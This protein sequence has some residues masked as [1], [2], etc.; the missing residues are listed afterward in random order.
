MSLF[1]KKRKE[2]DG[3]SKKEQPEVKRRKIWAISDKTLE[4]I[5]EASRSTMPNEFAGML[6][7]ERG[8]IINEILLLPGTISGGRSALLQLHM[9]PIDFTI[10]GTVH[11][12]PSYSSRPSE[13]DLHLFSRFGNT[14]IIVSMPF[15]DKSWT[16]YDRQGKIVKLEIVDSELFE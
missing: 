2:T 1:G 10:V 11:S 9:L 16:A 8:G 7:S 14:H 13:A 4:M 5:T 3:S 6:R 15:N 12:H